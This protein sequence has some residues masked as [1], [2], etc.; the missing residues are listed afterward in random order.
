MKDKIMRYI[1]YIAA[2]IT[3]GSSVAYFVTGK[4]IPGLTPF[5]LT[6]LM[7]SLAYSSF[8]RYKTEGNKMQRGTFIIALVAAGL[9]VLAGT[10]QIINALS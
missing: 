9:N 10:M 7:I 8:Q 3:I 2:V 6:I 1:G 4:S 5:A